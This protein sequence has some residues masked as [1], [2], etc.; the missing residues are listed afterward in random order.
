[1]ISVRFH[2]RGGQ[3]T[4]KGAE[5]LTRSLVLSGHHAQFIPAFGVERKGS[6][7]YGFFR[8]SSQPIRE[9]N[10]VYNPDGIVVLDDSLFDE[11]KVFEGV[12]DGAFL[13]VN[14]EDPAKLALPPQITRVVSVDATRIAR[15]ETGREIPN[16]VMLG[17]L[18]RVLEEIDRD[19][20][21]EDIRKVYGDQNYQAYIRGF[22]EST[23]A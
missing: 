3:G 1:M 9:N 20:L 16:T 21:A 8:L 14:T 13:V 19:A 10:Q 5:L 22:T 7:V 18:A 23:V 2:G 12:R 17:L 11:I 6:P 4:V 15:E